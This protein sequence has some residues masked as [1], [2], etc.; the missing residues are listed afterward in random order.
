MKKVSLAKDCASWSVS[1][2]SPSCVERPD[3]PQLRK[4][5]LV[6]EI[7][8]WLDLSWSISTVDT[9][10]FPW[11]NACFTDRY[12]SLHAGTPAANEII[13]V[14]M[15]NSTPQARTSAQLFLGTHT[16]RT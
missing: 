16:I 6:M 1:I 15:G 10:R 12:G 11:Q 4:N 5:I 14:S 7:P 13:N 3:V 9:T 2:Q 8:K